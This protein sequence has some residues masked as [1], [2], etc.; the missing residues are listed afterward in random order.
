VGGTYKFYD[1]ATTK[2]TIM[3]RDIHQLMEWYGHITA[4]NDLDLFPE[5]K[6]LKT[7][8]IILPTLPDIPILSDEDFPNNSA[9]PDPVPRTSI[10]E[11]D[12]EVSVP[13]D[14]A[15]SPRR[16][17]TSDFNEG[18][19]TRSRARQVTYAD[20][21]HRNDDTKEERKI[22]L[23]EFIDYLLVLNASLESDP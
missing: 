15:V 17:L 13:T 11:G 8:S 19:A 5:L 22:N 21:D 16:N 2:Q 6:K 4:T 7:D 14:V 3:S 1:P 10:A 12:P 9:I 20:V 23:E 18:A